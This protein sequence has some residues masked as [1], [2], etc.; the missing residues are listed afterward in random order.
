[1]IVVLDADGSELWT[2]RIDNDPLMFGLEIENAGSQA[3]VVLEPTSG[4]YW[5]A[6]VI[7]TREAQFIGASV[8]GQGVCNPLKGWAHLIDPPS[9]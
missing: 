8:G 6:D 7:T 4:W 3:E 2:K 1:M 9:P 5:A